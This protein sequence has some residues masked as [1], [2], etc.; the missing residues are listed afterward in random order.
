MLICLLAKVEM[1]SPTIP[2]M[3]APSMKLFPGTDQF[4]TEMVNHM[5]GLL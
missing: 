5:S 1:K 4:K 3:S 2:L